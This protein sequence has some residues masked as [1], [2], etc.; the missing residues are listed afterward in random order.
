MSIFINV[1]GTGGWIDPHAAR[2]QHNHMI[3]R[4]RGASAVGQEA[5]AQHT[6]LSLGRSQK[7]GQG[8]G[9]GAT[10]RLVFYVLLCRGVQ[11]WKLDDKLAESAFVQVAT[12]QEAVQFLRG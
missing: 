1:T 11:V 8:Q 4:V 7:Q 10:A 12:L 6:L 9:M 2:W 5:W 3:S